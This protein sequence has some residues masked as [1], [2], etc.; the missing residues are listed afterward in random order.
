MFFTHQFTRRRSTVKNNVTRQS[1][2]V[3]LSVGGQQKQLF[4][5][6]ARRPTLD[7][8]LPSADVYITVACLISASNRADN[9]KER[10]CTDLLIPFHR[11]GDRFTV[12]LRLHGASKVRLLL[13]LIEHRNLFIIEIFR[14]RS[15]RFLRYFRRF[16]T[17]ENLTPVVTTLF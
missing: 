4:P 3:D 11:L 13:L 10:G 6:L 7:S 2:D 14:Q 16:D 12:I 15:V 5:L 17:I 1:F 8:P 9:P